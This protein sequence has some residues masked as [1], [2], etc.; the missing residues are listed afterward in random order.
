M[1]TEN[2]ATT[3]ATDTLAENKPS[4]F[5]T[6]VAIFFEPTKAFAAIERRS[7][8]LLPLLLLIVSTSLMLVWY[9]QRVDFEWLLDKI[10]AGTP[11]SAAQE[12]KRLMKPGTMMMGSVFGEA[13]GTP[14]MFAVLA[15]YF[16]IVAKIKNLKIG[17]GKWYALVVWASVPNLLLALL[18][19]IQIVLTAGG[20]LEPSQLNPVSLNSLLFHIE[21]GRPGAS[22]ADSISLFTVWNLALMVI[23]FQAWTKLS[24]ITSVIAVLTPMVV[25]YGIWIAISFSGKAA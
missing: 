19:V 17:F 25:I 8:T 23:G 5:A 6:L 13:I 20:Q 12:G 2:I 3:N 24:R 21:M 1:T 11:D 22:L 7:M 15:C 10:F 9:Y 18:G 4:A 16:L 14:I